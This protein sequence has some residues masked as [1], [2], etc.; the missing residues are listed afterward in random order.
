MHRAAM[1]LSPATP[2]KWG[3]AV[4]FPSPPL[5]YIRE[6]AQGADVRSIR[7]QCSSAASLAKS[8]DV[9]VV[10]ADQYMSEAGDSPTLSLPGKQNELI[11]A[12]AAAHPHTIVVLVTG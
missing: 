5:R 2:T 6:H 3:E 7:H 11:S 9:A 10:F 8:A 1:R 12:V 4:Y